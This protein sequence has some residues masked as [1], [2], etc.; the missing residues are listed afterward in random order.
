MQ[1]VEISQWDT[2]QLEMFALPTVLVFDSQILLKSDLQHLSEI[3]AKN[4]QRE[5]FFSIKINFS[6]LIIK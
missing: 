3:I 4:N 5:E 2:Y 6:L 1:I